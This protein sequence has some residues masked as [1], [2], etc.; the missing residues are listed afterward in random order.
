MS[1][2]IAINVE[3]VAPY[4]PQ[5]V[6]G[7]TLATALPGCGGHS[8]G[9]SSPPKP[10]TLTVTASRGDIQQSTTITLDMH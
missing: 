10:Y 5:K 2:F 6:G 3:F 8:Q 1:R 9:S 4:R 7:M